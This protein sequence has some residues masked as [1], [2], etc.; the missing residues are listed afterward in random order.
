MTCDGRTVS[1]FVWVLT[2][3]SLPALW[4]ELL[5]CKT[6]YFSP[7]QRGKIHYCWREAKS[8]REKG[9][10]GEQETRNF[11]Q[12]DE[13][14]PISAAR[15]KGE[16]KENLVNVYV[17]SIFCNDLHE[18]WAKNEVPLE[19]YF[20]FCSVFLNAILPQ[21]QYTIVLHTDE[22]GL[23]NNQSTPFTWTLLAPT[24]WE[25]GTM[26]S[27]GGRG[28]ELV[29][30]GC[31]GLTETGK[32]WILVARVEGNTNCLQPGVPRSPWG[33]VAGKKGKLNME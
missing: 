5:H 2:T 3:P 1:I 32:H 28:P 15:C 18:G 25:T 8:V 7:F 14:N 30:S 12:G 17:R 16:R 23:Q 4:K 29:S 19:L 22:K 10:S 21:G 26:A 24:W 9:Q 13:N 27:R 6:S 31:G 11:F 20:G 33:W